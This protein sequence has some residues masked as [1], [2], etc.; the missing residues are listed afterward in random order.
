MSNL[1]R[2][3][4]AYEAWQECK[5]A[6][7]NCWLDI[8]ADNVRM[9]SMSN[10]ASA[11]TFAEERKSKAEAIAYFASLA[12][13]WTMIHWTPH[14]YVTEGDKIAVFSTCAWKNKQTG[15]AVETPIAH[16]LQFEN[17]KVASVIELFDS[18][19]VLAAATR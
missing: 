15:K 2:L 6:D 17:G 16:L 4:G 3:K 5:G 18:A 8:F 11:L 12:A 13:H 19:R 9:R 10:E 14:T 1:A 7:P